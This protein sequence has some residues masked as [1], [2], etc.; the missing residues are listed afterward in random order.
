MSIDVLIRREF[1]E[2][3]AKE[4]APLMVKLRSL[5]K[6]RPGYICSASLRCIEPTD[7]KAYLIRSTWE[8][9]EAWKDWF[10]SEARTAI[11]QQIDAIAGVSTEYKIYE[12]LV[13]G[14]FEKLC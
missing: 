11:Q 8:S 13:D 4:L 12:P 1:V 9:V 6:S 10:H 14:F 7:E 2:G 3:K 5:A